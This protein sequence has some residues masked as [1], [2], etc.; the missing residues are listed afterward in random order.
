MPASN[1]QKDS[2]ISL[3]DDMNHSNQASKNVVVEPDHI[4]KRIN[5]SV[6]V[7]DYVK[8]VFQHSK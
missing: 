1:F 4:F 2:S 6:I 8:Y 7:S 3:N 5:H